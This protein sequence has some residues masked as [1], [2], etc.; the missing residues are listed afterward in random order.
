MAWGASK[1]TIELLLKH[2]VE[3]GR[4]DEAREVTYLLG[5]EL[6]PQEVD[7]LVKVCI[8][9]ARI[10]EAEKAARIGRR[11]LSQEEIDSLVKVR[12]NKG[13]NVLEALRPGVSKETIDS[14]VKFYIEKG[15]MDDAYRAIKL[16][17][18]PEVIGS[19]AKTLWEK[20]AVIFC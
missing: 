11:K 6:L 4:T 13:Y 9:K 1:E 3:K 8:E 18:S 16:G 20:Y 14:V 19:F 2:C 5:R 7:I 15:A 12:I 17:A 10:D